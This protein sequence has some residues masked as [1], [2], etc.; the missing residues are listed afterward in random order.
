MR[1]DSG[2]GEGDY[3]ATVSQTLDLS[4]IPEPMRSKLE[5]QLSRLPSEA[6]GKLEA[7]LARL[8]VEHLEAAM[9]SP[10][11]QRLVNKGASSAGSAKS[12]G[13]STSGARPVAGKSGSG[14]APTHARRNDPNNHYNAT[15]GR[16]DSAS[17]PFFEVLLLVAAGL[18]FLRALG[19]G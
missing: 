4:R 19:V 8:P 10:L 9:A 7:Q 18:V 1:N 11:L 15:S 17:P 5:E 12:A 14:I 2:T 6:R 16:G 3:T 13:K